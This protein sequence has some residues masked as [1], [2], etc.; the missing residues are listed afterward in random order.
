MIADSLQ[1]IIFFSK[2]LSEIQ[3]VKKRAAIEIY[4]AF[5]TL[6]GQVMA[7]CEDYYTNTI[8]VGVIIYVDLTFLFSEPVA[9]VAGPNL[10]VTLTLL[11]SV[12]GI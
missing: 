3:A 6:L 5:C 9:I 10:V 7:S 4:S 12:L 8:C 1:I 11:F 2:L